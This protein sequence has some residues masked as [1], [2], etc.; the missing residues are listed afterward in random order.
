M[1][2]FK[3]LG[4]VIVML[5]AYSSTCF[6]QDKKEK[7]K[8]EEIVIFSVNM[9]CGNCQARIER[10]VSWE[11][12]VKDLKVDLEHKT[13]TIK[14]DPKKTSVEELDKAVE[15]LGFTSDVVKSENKKI[16]I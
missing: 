6:S 4:L 12:G 11:K 14:Y 13:V 3:I 2:L 10:H 9:T 15:S 8:K 7:K 16:D 5:F 1:K